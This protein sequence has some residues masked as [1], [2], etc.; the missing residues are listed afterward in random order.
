[1]RKQD[2]NKLSQPYINSNQTEFDRRFDSA[3]GADVPSAGILVEQIFG[4]FDAN[5]FGI[6]WWN[7]LP[8]EERILI[9]DYLYQCTSDIETNLVEA[10]LHYLEWLGAREKFNEKIA[11]VISRDPNGNLRMKMPPSKSPSDDLP[12]RT[13]LQFNG[14]SFLL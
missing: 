11:N 7:S 9:S 13:C 1:M 3:I 4:D 8:M 6:W 5:S 14:K 2:I 10:K 12:Y